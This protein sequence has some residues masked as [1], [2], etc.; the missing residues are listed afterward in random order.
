MAIITPSLPKGTRDFLP[1]QMVK[2][3]FVI[4]TVQEIFELYGYEPL[5]TP[6]L[7]KLK[8]LSGQYGDEGEKLTFKV[9]RRGTGLEELLSGREEFVIKDY[10]QLVDE[11][12]RY[13]LT[14][15]LSRVV[16][17]HQSDIT[18]PFKRYQIQPVWRAD[19]PQK[20]RYREFYQCDI[21]A[22]GTDSRLADA[23]TIAI[24]YSVL[25]TLGFK[26]F[27]IRINNRGLLN[28]IL[29]FAGVE[30]N[31]RTPVLIAIDKLDKIGFA[32]VEREILA[33]GLGSGKVKEILDILA[34]EGPAETLLAEVSMRCQGV[35]AVNSGV[36]E[37]TEV[38]KYLQL[39]GVPEDKV[40]L[41]FYLVRGLGYYTGLIQESVITEPKIGSLTGGGRYDR[42]IGKFLGRDIPACGVSFGI[43]RIID[44]MDELNLFPEIKTKTEILVSTFDASTQASSIAFAQKARNAGIKAETYF[45]ASKLKK[46]FTLADRKHIPYVIVIGPDEMQQG[47]VTLKNMAT[48]EQ[49]GLSE[50]EAIAYLLKQ[51]H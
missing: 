25:S 47:R 6:S 10:G 26:S 43:E 32:G 48:A 20:G 23:E 15:P 50:E 38:L 34:L 1:Q 17:M 51:R 31:Q 41:D 5:E 4:K 13:D 39:L 40:K 21:D 46:Q 33:A 2:R 12:L 44:V 27:K 24:V 9:L 28:G 3:Q 18:L 49:I 36:E 16:A 19:R 37:L 11:A 42:L 45:S 14:V 35:A 30:E 8:V 22:V 29:E 7:E